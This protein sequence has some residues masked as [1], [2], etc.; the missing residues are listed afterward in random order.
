MAA[1]VPPRHAAYMQ[2]ARVFTWF[3]VGLLLLSL[4]ATLILD[5]AG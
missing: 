1:T 2:I 3:V 4:V 5:A